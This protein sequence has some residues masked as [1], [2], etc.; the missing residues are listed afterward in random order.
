MKT[1]RT[2]LTSIELLVMVVIVI[3]LPAIITASLGTARNLAKIPLCANSLRQIGAAVYDYAQIYD[4]NLPNVVMPA[5]ISSSGA[6]EAHFYVQYREDHRVSP[7]STRLQP[8]RFA[9]LYEAG[10]IEDAR[11]FYC[12]ANTDAGRMYKSY[13]NP[14]PPNTSTEWGTLPQLY[15]VT[16]YMN[17]WVRSGYDWFPVDK[18]PTLQPGRVVVDGVPLPPPPRK[19]CRKFDNLDPNLPYSTDILRKRDSLSHRYDEVT[20]LNVLY[21]DGRVFFQDD[22]NVFIHRVWDI[23]PSGRSTFETMAIYYCRMLLLAGRYPDQGD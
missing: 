5:H 23:E 9:C 20:G 13:T 2:A 22:P 21:S 17:N 18:N 16:H 14:S 7:S 4:G 11:L 6:E 3:L 19:L 8:Y 10:L 15:N 1:K 12:P